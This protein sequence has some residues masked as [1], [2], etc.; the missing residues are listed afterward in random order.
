MMAMVVVRTVKTCTAEAGAG[1]E[2][3]YHQLQADDKE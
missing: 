3:K 1:K 2:R